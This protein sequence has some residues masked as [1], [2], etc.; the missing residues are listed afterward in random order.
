MKL[1]TLLA[2]GL[3]A[4]AGLSPVAASAQHHD[5]GHARHHVVRHHVVRRHIVR[6]RYARHH[7]H[8][9]VVWHHHHRVR[10]CY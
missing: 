6:H 9:R 3:V 7:R 2:A 10:R 1:V 4:A 8:C 5:R